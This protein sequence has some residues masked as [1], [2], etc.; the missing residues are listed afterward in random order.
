MWSN[1]MP[2]AISY[3][4]FSSGK[5]AVGSSHQRQQEAFTRWLVANPDYTPSDLEYKDLGKSGYHGDHIKDGGGWSNLLI[6]VEQGRIESGDVVLVEAMDR[7]GRL[8]PLDMIDIIRPVLNAGIA[9]I[10][11]DDGNKF[12]KESLEGSHI[13]LLVAKI[14]AAHSY[15]KQ[16]S[17]RTKASYAIRRE[18]AKKGEKVKRYVVAWLTTSGEL[19]AEIVPHIQKV[20]ELYISG[21]GKHAIASRLRASGVP[22]F[23][24]C[25]GTT[26][27]KWLN[28]KT[29]IGYWGD[30]PNVYPA[31]VTPEIFHQAQNRQREVKTSPKSYT[32][33][34]FLV[35]LVKCGTCGGG[36]G[37]ARKDGKPSSM[38]CN[39]LQRVDD[40]TNKQNIPYAV[41]HHIYLSSAPTWIDKAMKAIQLTDNEKRKLVL[42]V[43]RDEATA[44]I[45]RLARLLAKSEAPEVEAELDNATKRRA[46]IDIELSI[47]DRSTAEDSKSNSNSIIE[48]YD[49][50][51]EHDRF[52]IHDPVQL[53][54]LLKRAGYSIT[55]HPGKKLYLPDDDEP[56]I[57]KGILRDG[58]S[59]LGY[60]IQDGE[61]EYTIS[62][63]PP[64]LSDEDMQSG[65]MT[66]MYRR[67][68]KHVRSPKPL[69][70]S[71]E[72]NIKSIT[73]EPVTDNWY[74]TIKN[75]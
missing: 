53:S 39:R 73:V 5:Q 60:R 20:F 17:E 18:K 24:T 13:Y 66:H 29:A 16:L 8:P 68:Y 56:L 67:S 45:Q 32:S 43:E 38:R 10:T 19:K 47:L 42:G 31:V 50:M 4:R 51:L 15:S 40:C 41:I 9:I 35:G 44:S 57:Y 28:N 69:N 33:K 75:T 3:I 22:E 1:P 52:S 70:L 30:I 59:T 65:D 55:V 37:I 49:A 72:R 23:E 7:T 63:I 36:Y 58:N 54:A 21:V 48:G 25:T 11:L 2:K 71:G 64:G 74:T 6:A 46:A 12:D 14:Q 61:T 26:V 62:N 27:V 34:N